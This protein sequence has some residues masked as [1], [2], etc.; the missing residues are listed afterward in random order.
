MWARPTPRSE[1]LAP[2]NPP[3]VCNS[4]QPGC[5]CSQTT[6]FHVLALPRRHEPREGQSTDI[7][8]TPLLVSLH[9]RPCRSCHSLRTCGQNLTLLHKLLN[10]RGEVQC[11]PMC[12]LLL[13]ISTDDDAP[14]PFAPSHLACPRHDHRKADLGLVRTSPAQRRTLYQT[15]TCAASRLRVLEPHELMPYAQS[16]LHPWLCLRL[17]SRAQARLAG[18]LSFTSNWKI[19]ES[20][21][22]L[23]VTM[24]DQVP[25]RFACSDLFHSLISNSGLP[26]CRLCSRSALK[27]TF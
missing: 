9:V 8:C 26:L 23:H 19:P 11:Y 10:E 4:V 16:L 6:L 1:L 22:P 14:S 5:R 3:C 20:Q 27:P 17:H 2:A 15:S 25:C 18:L 13:T 7:Y 12:S 24:Q 21:L